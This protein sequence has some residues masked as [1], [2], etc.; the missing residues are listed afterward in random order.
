MGAGL[1]LASSKTA[2]EIR[3]LQTAI[4]AA[5]GIGLWPAIVENGAGILW[6]QEEPGS[7]ARSYQDLRGVLASLD[8]KHPGF[9]GF[10]D[11]TA[12][13][14]AERTSLTLDQAK[15][16]KQR[17][18]SEPGVWTGT[19]QALE[20]F[21]TDLAKH[22]VQARR[23]GRF[24]TLSF[25]HTKA[26]AV[27]SIIRTHRPQTTF[28]LGDAPNDIEMIEAADWG[29]VVHNPH[30]KPLPPLRGEDA[31]R[32]IRT[33]DSGPSGWSDAVLSLLNGLIDR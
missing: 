17:Q 13:D 25:A 19:P 23:G 33:Q 9:R 28:A 10:G 8:D 4:D 29:V 24:L 12:Q 31:G 22:G 32:I 3:P 27:A 1:V 14:V 20:S 21:Q 16:A 15:L 6:P 30:A 5:T 18:F 11:M 7:D 26:D 2:A